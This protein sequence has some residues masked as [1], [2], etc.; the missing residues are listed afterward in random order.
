MEFHVERDVLLQS[1]THIQGVVEKKNTLPILSNVLI[2]ATE[3]GLLVTAT[4]MDMIIS[5]KINANVKVNGSTTTGAQALYDIVRKLPSNSQLNFA[6]KDESKLK[7]ISGMSDYELTCL[8][9]N[10]FPIL[11]DNIEE[12]PT[13]IGSKSF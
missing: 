11:E 2:Q 5:E 12:E 6:L 8:S 1:L 4:D 10:E 9:S 13:V 3:E 7:L